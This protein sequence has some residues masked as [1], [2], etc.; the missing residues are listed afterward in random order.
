M[1][2]PSLSMSTFYQENGEVYFSKA[3]IIYNSSD[4]Q[5]CVDV[6]VEQ[7]IRIWNLI[8]YNEVN[9]EDKSLEMIEWLL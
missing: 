9:I 5:T 8:T 1:S 6:G 3:Y 2:F 4:I 7:T